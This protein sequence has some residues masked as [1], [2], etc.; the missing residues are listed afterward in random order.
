MKKG[1]VVITGVSGGIGKSLAD[2]FKDAGYYVI[3]L[4]AIES[5]NSNI[6][7]F[8]LL[9]LD[10]Y[11]VDLEYRNKMNTQILSYTSDIEVLINN[12][13]VQ[14][15]DHIEDL[16][17]EDWNKTL[18]VNLTS[19]LLLSQ[20]LASQLEANNGNII[21]IASIHHQQTKAKF[22]SYASSK[23]ALVGLTRALAI[24]FNGRV[25]VNS[26]SPAAIDTDMLRAGFENDEGKIKELNAIHPSGRIGKTDE[27]AQAALFIADIKSGFINGSNI[28]LDGGISGVLKDLD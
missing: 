13:A 19:P 1:T 15:L 4:D 17:I 18:N 5:S 26:I 21:N 7:K 28:S 11:A 20:L 14:L 6:D 9:D 3:G 23:S 2:G 25:R 24:D 12:A 27:V 22:I 10:K 8:L 16:K